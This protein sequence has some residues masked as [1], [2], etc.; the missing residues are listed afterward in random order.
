MM[1]YLNINHTAIKPYRAI[2]SHLQPKTELAAYYIQ[3]QESKKSVI[4]TKKCQK[5][6]YKPLHGH[7]PF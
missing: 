6:P 1:A 2:Q 3:F 5:W 7:F 4:L